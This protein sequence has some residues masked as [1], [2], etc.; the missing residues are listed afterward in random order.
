LAPVQI[1]LN[2]AG[3]PLSIRGIAA[4]LYVLILVGVVVLLKS[5]EGGD[6][7]D[8]GATGERGKEGATVG[9]ATAGFKGGQYVNLKT[10]L[11]LIRVASR[12]TPRKGR[13][14]GSS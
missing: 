7:M 8:H 11:R 9:S 2:A 3:V 12:R 10:R 14:S 4:S 6:L 13:S 1:L 5:G